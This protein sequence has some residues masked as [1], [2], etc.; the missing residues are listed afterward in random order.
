[1]SVL[2]N[3]CR[4]DLAFL[5]IQADDGDPAWENKTPHRSVELLQV[6]LSYRCVGGCIVY[7]EVVAGY[8]GAICYT[9][10]ARCQDN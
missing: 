6:S 5:E 2:W 3:V 10:A 8:T 7:A 1:M 9:M 4:M